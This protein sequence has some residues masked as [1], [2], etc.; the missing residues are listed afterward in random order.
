MNCPLLNDLPMP[1]LG[2]TGW[3]WTEESTRL[4]EIRTTGSQWPRV[5]LIVPSFNQGQFLEETLR[6]ILLQGYPDVEIIVIDG[7]SQDNSVE[8]IKKYERW[9]TSWSSVQDSGQSDAIN[10]G[11]TKCTGKY[12]NWNNADDVLTKGCLRVTVDALEENPGA[13]AVTGYMM[14]TDENSRV[15]SVNDDQPFLQGRSGFLHDTERCLSHLKCGCQPGGLMV[16]ELVKRVGGVDSD[17]HYAMDVDLFLKLMLIKPIY[18]VDFPVIMFRLHKASKTNTYMG[19]RADE[20]LRIAR[21]IFSQKNLPVNI[22][23][24]KASAY[25]S[26]HQNAYGYYFSYKWWFRAMHHLLLKH[27]YGLISKVIS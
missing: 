21:N 11:L 24:L 16:T 19:N 23:R 3:P 6:A 14:V 10:K 8:I 17:I 12:F 26:A 2:R 15:I 5:S 22:T 4:T 9:L 27:F 1:P 18:H 7:G 25:A 13:S 20:R